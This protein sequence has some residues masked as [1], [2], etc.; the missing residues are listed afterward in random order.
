MVGPQDVW[1]LPWLWRQQQVVNS[2]LNNPTKAEQFAQW[3]GSLFAG[4][5]D[6]EY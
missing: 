2:A 3:S 6:M 5:V 4:L 1:K